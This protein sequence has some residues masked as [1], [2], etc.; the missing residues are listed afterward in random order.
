MSKWNNRKRRWWQD[1]APHHYPR[2]HLPFSSTPYAPDTARRSAWYT[3]ISDRKEP[4]NHDTR[5]GKKWHRRVLFLFLVKSPP[6]SRKVV[7][8]LAGKSA[9][10]R[11]NNENKN[12]NTGIPTFPTAPNRQ[13]AL[14]NNAKEL[15][16]VAGTDD[17]PRC[18]YV[19]VQK[20]KT[21]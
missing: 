20:K 1:T 10:P 14:E 7:V 9:R 17:P 15:K 4:S 5:H 18:S 19:T 8:N 16:T 21:S 11:Q 2:S 3:C 13:P 12:E 6:R